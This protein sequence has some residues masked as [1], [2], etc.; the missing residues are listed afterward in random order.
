MCVTAAWARPSSLQARTTRAPLL[1]R[2]SA[3]ALP[4]PVFAPAVKPTQKSI[5]SNVTQSHNT[6]TCVNVS[7]RDGSF[8]LCN[9]PP[10][11][12][13]EKRKMRKIFFNTINNDQIGTCHAWLKIISDALKQN[14]YRSRSRSSHAALLYFYILAAETPSRAAADKTRRVLRKWAER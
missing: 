10:W 1:A 7:G 12:A 9:T 6:N 11:S 2:S 3:V 8:A 4:I 13:Y 5:L 14:T